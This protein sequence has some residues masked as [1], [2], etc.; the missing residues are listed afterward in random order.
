MRRAIVA[1]LDSRQSAEKQ[2][3]KW[4]VWDN[5]PH[6]YVRFIHGHNTWPDSHFHLSRRNANQWVMPP[7]SAEYLKTVLPLYE[8]LFTVSRK[9]D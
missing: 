5:P 1:R 7:E 9:E 3:C 4:V 2:R 8:Q 6:Y